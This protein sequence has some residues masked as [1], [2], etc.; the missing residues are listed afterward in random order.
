MSSLWIYIY[1]HIHIQT[2]PIFPDFVAHDLQEQNELKLARGY[3][4]MT[5]K[6]ILINQ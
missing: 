1:I 4:H 2:S 6:Y 5:F 3:I